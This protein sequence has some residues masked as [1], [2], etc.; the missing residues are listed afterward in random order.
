MYY[1]CKCTLYIYIQILYKYIKCHF[2]SSSYST[3]FLRKL[4]RKIFARIRKISKEANS[5]NISKRDAR[6]II[7]PMDFEDLRKILKKK[8]GHIKGYHSRDLKRDE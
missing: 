7:N 5:S 3:S 2:I 8:N 6:E 1:N 4:E